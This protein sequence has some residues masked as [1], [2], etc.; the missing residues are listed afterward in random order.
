MSNP[1]NYSLRSNQPDAIVEQPQ[2]PARRP[3]MP[4]PQSQ[5]SHLDTEDQSP[6]H[7]PSIEDSEGQEIGIMNSHITLDS[8][9]GQGEDPAKRFSYFERY[10]MF[11]SLKDERAAVAMP[12]HL[13]G[14]AKT[15]YDSLSGHTQQSMNLL[16]AAF[17]NKIQVIK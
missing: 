8:F 2:S 15:W 14:I 4:T 1:R 9:K 5:S 3:D 17:L 13:K 7:Q 11:N 16:K 6:V 12:F 10:A